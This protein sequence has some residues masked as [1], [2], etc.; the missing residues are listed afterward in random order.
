[1]R[2]GKKKDYKVNIKDILLTGVLGVI[3]F[4]GI[5]IFAQMIIQRV[6]TALTISEIQH[7]AFGESEE[8]E[9]PEEII[10][11]GF[12]IVSGDGIA[13]NKTMV[14]D[15]AVGHEVI[16]VTWD[17]PEE[18]KIDFKSLKKVNPDICA[19]ISIENTPINYPIL[20]ANTSDGDDYYL[21]RNYKKKNDPHGSI[22]IRS[23]DNDILSGFD[24][25]L[26]GHNMKDGTMFADVHKFLDTGYAR[27]RTLAY[28]YLPDGTVKKGSMVACYETDAELLS[29]KYNDFFLESDRERYIQSFENRT[30][31]Y[32][33]YKNSLKKN[34]NKLLTLSTCC[35]DDD[36][37]L[38]LQFAF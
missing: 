12:R 1:M 24:T 6:S 16:N 35:K 10:S 3:A 33:F 18:K 29:K 11:N 32:K 27:T 20:K 36:K 7:I 37:R 14:E 38:L 5:F 4:A 21:T 25:V 23:E 22:Y 26:Y 31:N 9:E 17:N 19:W 2:L 30:N 28:I 8:I 13:S 34:Q 15:D